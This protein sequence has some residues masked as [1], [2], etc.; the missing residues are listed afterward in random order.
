M[1]FANVPGGLRIY[2]E[3]HGTGEPVLLLM[4]TGADHSFWGPQIPDY[5]ARHR[6]IIPNA[7]R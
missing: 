3:E 7:A 5:S 4:G 2:Y 6:T 1:P